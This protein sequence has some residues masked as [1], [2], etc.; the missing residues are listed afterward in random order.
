MQDAAWGNLTFENECIIVTYDD[1]NNKTSLDINRTC[2]TKPKMKGLSSDGLVMYLSG[3]GHFFDSSGWDND[4]FSG[5]AGGTTL[6]TESKFG[7]AFNFS[8]NGDC[9]NVPAHSASMD[10][11]SATITAWIRPS[12]V[13]NGFGGIVTKND[14]SPSVRPFSCWQ[15]S[16]EIEVWY[17]GGHQLSSP[18]QLVADEWHHVVCSYDADTDNVSIFIN[19]ELVASTIEATG[20]PTDSD[21]PIIVGYRGHN[22]PDFRGQMDEVTLWN[23]SLHWEEVQGMYRS[24]EQTLKDASATYSGGVGAYGY[25]STTAQGAQV[26]T[27]IKLGEGVGETEFLQHMSWN[28]TEMT[29]DSSG[30]YEV[31]VKS[32]LEGSSVGNFD[33]LL[34]VNDVAK[35]DAV[36]NTHS[37]TDPKEY[38]ASW[39]GCLEAGDRVASSVRSGGGVFNMNWEEDSSLTVKRISK[40]CP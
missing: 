5:C 31:N 26:S 18:A 20:L 6:T 22:T 17:G 8:N 19:G 40:V 36:Y 3:D 27:F 9:V 38:T 4:G 29:L 1:A 33:L 32:I 21:N 24:G 2:V 10:S 28:G 39:M 37:S 11:G 14:S 25:V 13:S 30:A 15:N 35:I 34:L 7:K 23:R 12:T 16:A